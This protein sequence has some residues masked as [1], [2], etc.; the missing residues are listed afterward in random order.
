MLIDLIILSYNGLEVNKDFIK[1]YKLNTSKEWQEKIRLIWVDNNSIDGTYD[2]ISSQM[3]EIPNFC[4]ER[5]NEN[6]GVI[7]GRNSGYD[8][9]KEIWYTDKEKSKYIMILDNDQFVQPDWIEQHLSVLEEGNYDLIGIEAWEMSQ[10][11][12]PI[13]K[14]TKKDIGQPFQYIGC[15]GSLMKSE[16][17]EICGGLYDTQFNPAYFEDPDLC[18][19]ANEKGLKI[20]W[21]P[22]AKI[23]HL[24]H[25]TLGV[26]KKRQEIFINSYKKFQNKWL[27]KNIPVFK[28]KQLEAYKK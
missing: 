15:G 1:Y 13:K 14:L 6:L 9:C 17:P 19:R 11:L 12:A 8:F 27:N 16:V 10:R 24:E 20:G 26:N 18:F 5:N 21:N 23:I 3:R 28:Q 25:S 4:L 7:G 2:F 22:Y